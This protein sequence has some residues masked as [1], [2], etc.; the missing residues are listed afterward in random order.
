MWHQWL[1]MELREQKLI[2]LRIDMDNLANLENGE[3]GGAG[4][5]AEEELLNLKLGKLYRLTHE[6]YRYYTPTGES[7]K[8][9]KD[10]SKAQKMIY[11]NTSANGVGKTTLLVNILTNLI[12]PGNNPWLSL[13]H[14]SEPTR[15][16]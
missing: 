2:K 13:I 16:Y 4:L 9:I 12:Y 14:I 1:K 7:E 11:V 6:R 15:P 8:F 10:I 3:R 5:S